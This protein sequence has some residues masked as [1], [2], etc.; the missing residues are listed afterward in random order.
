MCN[1]LDSLY[2]DFVRDR[3]AN[4]FDLDAFDGV[5]DYLVSVFDIM[6][7]DEDGVLASVGKEVLRDIDAVVLDI[8]YIYGVGASDLFLGFYGNGLNVSGTSAP[9]KKCRSEEE[10]E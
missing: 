5:K 3:V 2:S 4:N 1:F 9:R 8:I 7:T 10:D 6:L